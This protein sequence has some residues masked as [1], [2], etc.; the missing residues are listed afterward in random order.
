MDMGWL[1]SLRRNETTRLP[2]GTGNVLLAA[3]VVG[4]VAMM[5]LPLPTLLLDVLI[6]FNISIA[7]VLLLVSIY[8][9]SPLRFAVFPSILL[10][11]TLYRLG[12][13]VS[14]TRLILL[15]ADAGDVIA[16]F[17]GFVVGNNLVVG[18]VIF[19]IL[20]LIQFIVI[21][22]GSER[23][24]EVA[25]RFTLDAMPGRQM[26]ID[27]DL[28]TGAL[29][30]R[31]ARQARSAL[32]RESQLYGAMDGAMKFVKGDAI[33]GILIT[34][35][36]ISGG[37]LIGTLQMNMTLAD[38][39]RVYS[40]LTI[41][42]GLVSQ[43][44]A[45]LISTAAG[46]VVTRV[47]SEDEQ[48]QLGQDIGRQVLA[49][50][51]AIALAAGLMALLALLPGLP[52]VP[53]LLLAL[54]MGGVAHHL[55]R[56]S[57]RLEADRAARRPLHDGEDQQP[58]PIV[59][60]VGAEHA[61]YADDARGPAPRR[62]VMRRLLRQVREL[63]LR[64]LGVALPRVRV[65]I[66][67]K[68]P[69]R[70][71]EV[72]LFE[73]PAARAQ[74]HEHLLALEERQ[75]LEALGARPLAQAEVT[76]LTDAAWTVDQRHAGVLEEADP[77]VQL[78][79]AAT[80]MTLHLGQVL[81]ARA[82]DFVGIQQTRDMLDNL[83]ISHPSLVSEVVPRRVSLA[84]LS[85]VLSA[86]VAEQISIRDLRL[87]LEA[88][89]ASAGDDPAALA[90]HVRRALARTISFTF[91]GA[92][93]TLRALV[94]DPSVEGVVRDA[95][96]ETARGSSLTLEPGLSRDLVAAVEG[97]LPDDAGDAPVLL[98]HADLRRHLRQLIQHDLPR[99]RVLAFEEL[100]PEVEVETVGVVRPE[101]MGTD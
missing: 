18:A 86:L 3:L 66:S 71:Y 31:Q 77:P 91:G 69:A 23:V 14:S 13:N 74:T 101:G 62:Q 48:G 72:L 6:T 24:A 5:I 88:L 28:R 100:I 52:A 75:R 8:V 63:M 35:I 73:I 76:G 80:Q 93:G 37:L 53:F 54:V 56:R 41:G 26:A 1:F 68:L 4:I 83:E 98:A 81:R 30:Q 19:V 46:V 10:I 64:E 49:H 60:S 36:N 20:T 16:S 44:P 32:Q 39:A 50:P 29:D 7:V 97:S 96:K 94:L 84:T 43:I 78:V 92:D 57:R 21:A 51:R 55:L 87:I 33:A 42:D 9:S 38:A 58:A 22:R 15:Q 85:E 89:A 47:A 67:D 11:T 2:A 59:L 17:G 79:D 40:L 27:A 95:I 34:A 82:A 65:R 25:A 61:E 99:V 70:G 90:E 12:L 45:L